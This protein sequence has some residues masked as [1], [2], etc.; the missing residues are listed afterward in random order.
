M[1]V[2]PSATVMFGVPFV[3]AKT[4]RTVTRYNEMTGEPY[5]RKVNESHRVLVLS[6]GTQISLPDPVLGENYEFEDDYINEFQFGH[7]TGGIGLRL[8][9][10]DCWYDSFELIELTGYEASRFAALAQKYHPTIADVLQTHARL[11]VVNTTG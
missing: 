5:E 2:D 10:I 9:S 1:G 4:P 8:A 6:G 7:E 11:I 3:Y